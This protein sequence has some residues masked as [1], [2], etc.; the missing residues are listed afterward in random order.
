MRTDNR[1]AMIILIVLVVV[2]AAAIAILFPRYFEKVTDTIPTGAS[3]EAQ[4][5]PYL[6]ATRFLERL[7]I[8]VN[9]EL[10]YADLVDRSSGDNTQA[11]QEFPGPQDTLVMTYS[12]VLENPTFHEP[13]I[14][15][16]RKGGHLVLELRRF[17][18]K[19]E[20]STSAFEDFLQVSL[21]YKDFFEINDQALT[22][23]EIWADGEILD[24]NF[25]PYSHLVTERE[26][27]QLDF[28]DD[29]GSHLVEF[30]EGKGVVTVLSDMEIWDNEHIA[31]Y[32][33]AA[34][35]AHLLAERSGKVFFI[36]ETDMP[37][38]WS[39]IWMRGPE[40]ASAFLIL[41]SLLIWRLYNRFGPV[42]TLSDNIRRSLREHLQASGRFLWQHRL[43]DQL[44]EQV[45][46][47]LRQHLETRHP[48]W[49]S[50][51]EQDQAIWLAEKAD[52][53][54]QAVATALRDNPKQ[55]TEFTNIIRTLQT[56]RNKL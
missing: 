13:I 29:N 25:T 47:E 48:Q 50:K 39:L 9:S 28:W 56:L 31:D 51:N 49:R 3:L 54:E 42:V 38:L 15:W 37:S 20:D 14:D 21:D 52:L 5:N 26:D 46:D 33:H 1:R 36:L 22:E 34:F 24:V 55:T 12:Y 6:G 43:S 44:L 2:A 30:T 23:V 45:R 17:P 18:D 16:I 10:R 41:I 4:R 35:F 7:D 19:G 11:D 27:L 53:D 40:A 32:D 8:T